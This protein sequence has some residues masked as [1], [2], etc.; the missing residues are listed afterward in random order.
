MNIKTE[1]ALVEAFAERWQA[2][3][4][5]RAARDYAKVSE[6]CRCIDAMRSTLDTMGVE[7]GCIESSGYSMAL[8]RCG[9]EAVAL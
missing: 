8:S 5:A 6:E 7:W 4:E 2:V 3:Y 1:R 9:G